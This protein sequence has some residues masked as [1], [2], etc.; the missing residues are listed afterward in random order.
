MWYFKSLILGKISYGVFCSSFK[1]LL[2]WR[3]FEYIAAP[4]S[5]SNRYI[6]VWMPDCKNCLLLLSPNPLISFCFC[7]YKAFKQQTRVH[8]S[9]IKVTVLLIYMWRNIWP[10]RHLLAV[11]YFAFQQTDRLTYISAHWSRD[12]ISLKCYYLC[13]NKENCIQAVPHDWKT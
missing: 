1:H 9:R 6:S 5:I 12:Y 2:R 3:F 4:W 13:S 7:K 11:S 10:C 8:K